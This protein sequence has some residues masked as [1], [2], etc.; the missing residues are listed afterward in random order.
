MGIISHHELVNM[1]SPHATS[2]KIVIRSF[3]GFVLS[4]LAHPANE[5]LPQIGGV[6]AI[7]DLP[8]RGQYFPYARKALQLW[9][10]GL[11]DRRENLGLVK[12]R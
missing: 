3:A 11:S 10:K 2:V 7:L 8:L 5:Y 12:L 9:V 4:F 1:R 6:P